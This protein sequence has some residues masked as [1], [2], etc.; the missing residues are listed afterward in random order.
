MTEGV[1]PSWY[2][3]P[4]PD[5]PRGMSGHSAQYFQKLEHQ[6]RVDRENQTN[7]DNAVLTAFIVVCAF[8]IIGVAVWISHYR[9]RL[10][11]AADQAAV[12]SVAA[13]IRFA[14]KINAKR[15]DIISRARHKNSQ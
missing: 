2:V 3:D 5:Q 4:D 8:A 10:L 9:K 15:Q 11:A 12:S 14:G 6:Y 1:S 7:I 13:S